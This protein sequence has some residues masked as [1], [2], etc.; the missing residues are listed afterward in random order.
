MRE[1]LFTEDYL[2]TEYTLRSWLLTTD[3]KRIGLIYMALITAFFFVGGAAITVT[4]P[5]SLKLL[6][7]CRSFP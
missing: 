5:K 3:H 1:S 6:K 2:T 7:L 4:R